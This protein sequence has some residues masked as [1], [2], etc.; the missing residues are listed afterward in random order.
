[1]SRLSYALAAIT[2]IGLALW[3]VGAFDGATLT[4]SMPMAA[5][6]P[7]SSNHAAGA[8]EVPAAAGP[9][10]PANHAALDALVA[11]EDADVRDESAAALAAIS[12]EQ[13]SDA[14]TR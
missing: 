3:Q 7:T 5:V 1:M 13:E 6:T 12:F 8:P 4:A 14:T 10:E 2:G 11:A 9:E